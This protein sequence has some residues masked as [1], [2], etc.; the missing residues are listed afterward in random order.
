MFN[1]EPM[2]QKTY[3]QF[4]AH[5]HVRCF[6]GFPAGAFGMWCEACKWR[7]FYDTGDTSI[8]FDAKGDPLTTTC[9]CGCTV[10]KTQWDNTEGWPRCPDCQYI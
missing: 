2:Q 8:K 4:D 10:P 3:P 9:S 7:T 5:A 6:Y 1:F